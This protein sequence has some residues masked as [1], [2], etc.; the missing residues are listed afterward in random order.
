MRTGTD[1]CL[2]ASC[3]RECTGLR[4]LLVQQ[5]PKLQRRQ[6]VD[7]P[8]CRYDHYFNDWILVD[9][10]PRLA[11]L[12]SSFC[13]FGIQYVSRHLYNPLRHI[14]RLPGI[15]LLLSHDFFAQHSIG[16]STHH[17]QGST[18][19]RYFLQGPGR[20]RPLRL[21]VPTLVDT[22][23]HQGRS[24]RSQTTAERV[25]LTRRLYRDGNLMTHQSTTVPTSVGKSFVLHLL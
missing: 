1:G 21:N 2:L 24:V 14:R 23:D 16:R 15:I 6:F 3:T 13:S 10:N 18:H 4:C 8:S 17:L 19:D 5:G 11:A 22:T 20:I 9:T 7:S 12:G 25:P